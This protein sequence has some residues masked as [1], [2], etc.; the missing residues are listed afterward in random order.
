MEI[1]VGSRLSKKHRWKREIV[2]C[3]TTRGEPSICV[4]EEANQSEWRQGRKT[5]ERFLSLQIISNKQQQLQNC[6]AIACSLGV[7]ENKK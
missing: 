5:K 3:N 2:K 7:S 1:N 6:C 4:K